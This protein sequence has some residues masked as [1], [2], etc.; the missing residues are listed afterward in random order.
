VAQRFSA[1]KLIKIS[2]ILEIKK[3]P[4]I[5]LKNQFLEKPIKI[6]RYANN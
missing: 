4:K 3:S 2:I 5:N 1:P 6:K